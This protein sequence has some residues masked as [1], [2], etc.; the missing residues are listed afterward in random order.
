MAFSSYANSKLVMRFG[1][2][3]LLLLALGAFTALA[4]IHFVSAASIGDS[5]W[6]FVALQAATMG[7]FGLIGANAG[8]LAMEPLGRIAGTASSLQGLIGTVGGALIGLAIGQQF[9][10]TLV[11]FLAGFTLSGGAALLT[12]LWANRPPS[13]D[14]HDEVEIDV[15]EIAS[16]PG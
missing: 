11:P 10:G 9:N 12:A 15:E 14:T 6:S 13:R 4:A 16:R 3:R 2:R 8:A 5:I 1:S 7:C